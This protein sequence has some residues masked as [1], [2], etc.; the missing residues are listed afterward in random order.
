MMMRI[1]G[2]FVV[3]ILPTGWAVAGEPAA[4]VSGFA[5]D[6]LPVCTA[7]QHEP[8]STLR[9]LR[10]RNAVKNGDLTEQE[11]HLPVSPP[12]ESP[13]YYP[14]TGHDKK[15]GDKHDD[16]QRFWRNQRRQE[17]EIPVPLE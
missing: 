7:R 3:L 13:V 12:C 8:N 10:L 9:A 11:A 5:P 2:M 16:P 15:H 1:W 4:S 6:P 17:Y 14:H